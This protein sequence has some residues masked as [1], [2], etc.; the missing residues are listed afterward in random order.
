MHIETRKELAELFEQQGQARWAM[1]ATTAKERILKLER[2]RAAIL[3]RQGEL[4][5]A[6]WKDYHKSEFE[7]WL[8]EVFPSI[9]E[10]DYTKK[11]LAA[12]MRDA[13]TRGTKILPFAKSRLRYEPKGR[14]LIMSPWNYPFQLMMVPIISAI[15]AG[16]VIMAK[17]SNKTP[18]TAAFIA[19]L[20]GNL[21][22]PNEVAVV[23]GE[24]AVL[25]ELLLEMPF[26]HIF[27]TGSPKV[28]MHVG[29]AAARTHAGLTLELG[30]KSPTII[31]PDVN[32]D[33]AAQKIMWGK[34]LNAG[35]TCIAP[36]YLFCPRPLVDSFVTAARRAV[37][38]AYGDSEEARRGSKDLVQIV[39]IRACERHKALVEDAMKKGARLELGGIFDTAERYAAPT[40]LVDVN[41]DMA[42]M[43]E[44]IFGPILPVLAYD[45]IEEVIDFIHS[46]P[47]PL[48]LYVFGKNRRATEEILDRTTS[49]SAC[50]N[51]LIVQVENPSV[52]FGGIGMS[53]T[54]NYHG[55]Y[56]FK[57]FSHE[58]NILNGGPVNAT[59]GFYPPYSGRRRERSR[60][61]LESLRGMKR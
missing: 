5:K 58:R 45:S 20:L 51:D 43:D 6:V 33:D 13:N 38:A 25:G 15:A 21:F 42:I 29:E 60:R 14:V 50:V 36:D 7:A 32:M 54:G 3:E 27:F 59:K 56:G 11:H 52:P 34:C 24:G 44:E 28:G 22:P 55:H 61:L 57:T 26:D 41:A 23:E 47:K 16:N 19:S 17:P 18:N 39:D 10:L 4:Y 30:G 49:G 12:W 48:A 37:E 8:T 35:Q 40:I 2:L 53:G 1:E 31:L 9:E 46:R